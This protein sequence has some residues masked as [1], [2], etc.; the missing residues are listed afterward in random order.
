MARI[1]IVDDNVQVR[2]SIHMALEDAGYEVEEAHN[3]NMGLQMYREKPFDLV[4]TDIIMPEKEGVEMII[5]LKNEYPEAK[6]IAMSGYTRIS[7]E[8]YLFI[9]EKLGSTKTFTKPI[10]M[11]ELLKT[12]KEIL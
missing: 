4:I 1:L 2:L 9:A 6:I 12:V 5:D 7:P 11:N 3:G 8:Y 10:E